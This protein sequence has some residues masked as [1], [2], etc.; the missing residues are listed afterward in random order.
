MAT[1]PDITLIRAVS[2]LDFARYGY[3]DDATGN[4]RLG[5][6]LERAEAY[7]SYVTGRTYA[8]PQ[9]DQ[10]PLVKTTMDQAVQ[11]RT[12]QVVL[13]L[14]ADQLD[15]VA[16]ID[17]ITSFSAGSYTESRKDPDA[18]AKQRVLNP[19][20]ALDDI[21]WILL[22]LFPGETNDVVSDRFDW[23]RYVLGLGFVAPA[24]QVVEVD[25]SRGLG[26]NDWFTYPHNGPF[27]GPLPE[28]EDSRIG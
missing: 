17:L 4:V 14:A 6:Q 11:M 21:L 18:S 25:W 10:W 2:D 16:D 15:T 19:W 20:R 7:I 27:F 22:G 1:A 3:G 9:T 5:V 24:W 26:L 8:Q 23:W 28:V 12:E 13:S